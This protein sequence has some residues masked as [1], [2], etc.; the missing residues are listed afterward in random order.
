[1][2]KF[3]FALLLAPMLV[4]APAAANDG[5]L[6]ELFNACGDIS[7][8]KKRLKCFDDALGAYKARKTPSIATGALN[9]AAKPESEVVT[10]AQRETA[11]GVEDKPQPKTTTAQTENEVFDQEKFEAEFGAEHIVAAQKATKWSEEPN[12]IESEIISMPKMKNGYRVFTLANGQ[13][14]AQIERQHFALGKGKVF[15]AQIYRSFLNTSYRIVVR[16][17]NGRRAGAVRV[18]RLK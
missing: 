4:I 17:E 13:V 10:H 12:V 15:T 9:E 1:M 7:K 2:K 5:A 8:N 3:L 6:E 18:K 11:F 14:W 16:K